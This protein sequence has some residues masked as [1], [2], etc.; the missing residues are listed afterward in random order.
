MLKETFEQP[1]IQRSAWH[2]SWGKLN[3]QTFQLCLSVCP[4]YAH[5][6]FYPKKEKKKRFQCH[7]HFHTISN[8]LSRLRQSRL[9]WETNPPSISQLR[10][11]YRSLCRLH[12][13]Q[14]RERTREGRK[15]WSPGV[16]AA[17]FLLPELPHFGAANVVR[18]EVCCD[19]VL[20]DKS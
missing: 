7:Q 17:V 18:L 3:S 16:S 10:V 4:K 5:F 12:A 8:L 6:Q 15:S 9:M 1:S 11:L 20:R 14:K 19:E 2:V 13:R